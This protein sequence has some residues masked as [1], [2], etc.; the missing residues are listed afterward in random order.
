MPSIHLRD[1]CVR[2]GGQLVITGISVDCDG[3]SWLGIVG[4][5][6]SGKTTL[7]RSMAGRLPIESGRILL[8]GEDFSEDR[9]GRAERIGFAVDPAALPAEFTPEEI[10]GLVGGSPDAASSPE[11]AELREALRLDSLLGRRCGTLSS[12]NAQR[13]A[14]FAAFL[15]RPSI[16]I[17]DEPFN[18]LDPLTAYDLKIALGAYVA[19]HGVLLITALHD[20]TTLTAYCDRGVLMGAGRI[21]WDLSFDELRSGLLDARKFEEKMAEK[22]RS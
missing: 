12:G 10:F 9:K 18:W 6:G 20:L 14:I 1:L 4:A 13:I 2:R 22:L 7:L 17:L 3:P 11:L 8:D 19:R 5:N 21:T 15:D 16:V